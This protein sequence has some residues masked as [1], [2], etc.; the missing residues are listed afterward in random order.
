MTQPRVISAEWG[1]LLYDAARHATPEQGWFE[2][3][4]WQRRGAI[5][6]E[7]A[8][9]GSVLVVTRESETWVLRHYQRGGLVARLVTDHYLWLGLERTRSFREWRLLAN[10]LA[11]GLPVP[12]PI[13]ARVVR[14][15]AIY[16]ADIITTYLPDT[17]KLS[18]YIAEGQAPAGVWIRIG[19]ML[20]A[21]H[22]RGVD[23]PDLT[24]HNILLDPRGGL[25]LVDFDNAVVRKPG[26]WQQAGVDRFKRSLRKVA[27]E[28]GTEFDPDAWQALEL[29]YRGAPS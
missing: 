24:A 3:D 29:A 9:R 1:S 28:T 15:G 21:F 27:L 4:Y 13:A 22:A 11:A 20:R 10:L 19:D 6:Q 14:T 8:G 5:V 17:R 18:A 23:H 25:F 16:T 7:T 26:R 12:N 2:R